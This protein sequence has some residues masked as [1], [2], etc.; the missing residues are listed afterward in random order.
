MDLTSKLT[1]RTSYE[2][3]PDTNILT[4]AF[5]DEYD[6]V[7]D[8]IRIENIKYKAF[9]KA[10]GIIADERI[11]SLMVQVGQRTTYTALTSKAETVFV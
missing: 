3:D 10:L 4:I 9:I 7:I 6:V 5:K 8:T 11:T 2:V 1:I